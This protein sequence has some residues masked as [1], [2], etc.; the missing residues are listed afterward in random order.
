MNTVLFAKAHSKRGGAR[1]LIHAPLLVGLESNE[2]A[3]LGLAADLDG[4]FDCLEPFVVRFAGNQ[5]PRVVERGC[6]A[7][8]GHDNLHR[9]V[10]AKS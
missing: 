3:F 5:S 10:D 4:L 8:A 9:G 2:D 7:G 6:P 1:N